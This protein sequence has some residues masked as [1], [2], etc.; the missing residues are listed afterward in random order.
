MIEIL[1]E[2]AEMAVCVKP[3]GVECQQQLPAL[4]AEQL[5]GAFWPVHRLDKETGGVMVLARTPGAAARLSA[6]V[7]GRAVH[8]TYL[9]VVKGCPAAP[10]DRWENWLFH[11]AARNKSYVVSRPRR[12]V[13]AA[14]L[15][16][17]LLQTR[18]QG[19][20]AVSLVQVELFTGRTHQIRVQ[21]A[22]RGLPLLGDRRY[23]GPPADGLAL[24]AWRLALPMP[25][26][27]MQ[28]FEA[29]PPALFLTNR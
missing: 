28:T 14:A 21:F 24:W 8:K 12:G 13:K 7:A 27:Q 2:N 26:G 16:Y 18:G 11:D 19:S 25:N 9:A 15:A 4:L 5:G 22:H 29:P 17:T 20:D 1:F 10:A 3:A 6:L 23:G